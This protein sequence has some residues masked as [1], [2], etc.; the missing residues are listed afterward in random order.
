VEVAR[1][2]A[3]LAA[4]RP[5]YVLLEDLHW[6][7]PA[8]IEL[9]R[10]IAPTLSRSAILLVGTYRLDELT[11]RH[12]LFGHIPALVRESNAARLEPCRLTSAAFHALVAER[13]RLTAQ[14]EARL[15]AYLERHADGNP[16]FAI[17]LLR[18]L[19]AEGLLR[20]GTGRS[21]LGELARLVVPTLLQ[22]VIEGRIARLGEET[23]RA[24]AVAAV[25][26][27]EVPLALWGKASDLDPEA[28]VTIAEQAVD[29]HLLEADEDGT[30]VRFVHAL[31]R[32]ALYNG[33]LPPRRRVWHRTVGEI[34]AADAGA[35]PDA[36]AVHFQLAGDPR[37]CEWLIRSGD[38]AQRAYAWLTAADRLRAAANLLRYVDGQEQRY[39]DLVFRVAY[40][41]RFSDP[42]SSIAALDD[43]ERLS[44]WVGDA[45]MVA[46]VQYLRGVHL[47]YANRFRPGLVEMVT[48]LEA[49]AARDLDVTK[50][51][52]AMGVWFANV[53]G[54]PNEV[55]SPHDGQ[56]LI[57]LRAAGFDPRQSVHPYFAASAGQLRSSAAMAERFIAGLEDFSGEPAS[58]PGDRDPAPK[59]RP[60]RQPLRGSQPL[61]D[62]GGQ[63]SRV[64]GELCRVFAGSRSTTSPRT[65]SIRF[66]SS[67]GIRT[68][69][70][71]AFSWT[72]SGRD[73]PMIA[74]ATLS[75]CRTQAMA[76]CASESP[77]SSATG[78]NA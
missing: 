43:A 77:S 26:G 35:D 45:V 54:A 32:G 76:S 4:I 39:R 18:A 55:G 8:S 38:R 19:E 9:L 12:P 30:R 49:F 16:F 46:E 21:F 3:E 47:G 42:A 58:S 61:G 2:L 34:L 52:I 44:G 75:F 53:I 29:A 64:L 27:Q 40:L 60:H 25:V 7:D 36:V 67:A 62:G 10:Q 37:A 65:S 6:A 71:L 69:T 50:E 20:V 23:R 72:C 28:L 74:V 70:A 48:A 15:V 56:V 1:F 78:R 22:Q 73:A 14:D 17:E 24:L 68:P 66:I 41:L 57:R 13:Y 5:I 11:R 33:I 51:Q 59:P 31:T 63:A